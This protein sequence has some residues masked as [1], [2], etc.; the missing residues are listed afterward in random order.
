M[1]SYVLERFYFDENSLES[2]ITHVKKEAQGQKDKFKFKIEV[3]TFW[4][5]RSCKDH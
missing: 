5:K 4:Q 3:I 2:I 1:L